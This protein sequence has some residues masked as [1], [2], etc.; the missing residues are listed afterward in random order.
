[1]SKRSQILCFSPPLSVEN[2]HGNKVYRIKILLHQAALTKFSILFY[3]IYTQ[4]A[5]TVIISNN[6]LFWRNVWFLTNH[7]PWVVQKK[8][9]ILSWN[10]KF[11][12]VKY[13]INFC[14]NWTMGVDG[15]MIKT[16][17]TFDFR[18]VVHLE[19]TIYSD[20]WLSHHGNYATY[21][22]KRYYFLLKKKNLGKFAENQQQPFQNKI[23]KVSLNCWSKFKNLA[24]FF[25]SIWRA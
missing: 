13:F 4:A 7:T 24:K 25:W 15:I 1:M 9:I 12:I 3:F 22:S 10:K 11:L 16:N 21:L 18:K 8:V 17:K 5:T 19:F 23:D 14:W 2:A 20:F 6:V